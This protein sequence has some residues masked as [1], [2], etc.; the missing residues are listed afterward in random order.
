M[1]QTSKCQ[2]FFVVSISLLFVLFD[3][4]L[5]GQPNK[6]KEKQQLTSCNV[7]ALLLVVVFKCND[8][9]W[10]TTPCI[11]LQKTV[12]LFVGQMVMGIISQHRQR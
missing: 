1:V 9:F 7:S 4:V 5:K 2:C 10:M 11:C 3:W 8:Q 12:A 6:E